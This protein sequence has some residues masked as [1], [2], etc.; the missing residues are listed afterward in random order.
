[1]GAQ[2]LKYVVLLREWS[3]KIT[4]C[5]SSGK[6]VTA[7]C[8]KQGICTKTYY[9]EKHVISEATQKFTLPII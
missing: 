1:M 5:H 8:A 3:V 4:A 7:W 6:T 9:W 2:S